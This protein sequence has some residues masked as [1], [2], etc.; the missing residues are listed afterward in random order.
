MLVCT[1][2]GAVLAETMG[3]ELVTLDHSARRTPAAASTP[4]LLEAL[5][6]AVV[7]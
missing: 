5:V 7:R 6:D 1:E 2:A 4:S 3:R